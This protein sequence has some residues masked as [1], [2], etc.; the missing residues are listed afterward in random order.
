MELEMT[1]EKNYPKFR[2]N[3]EIQMKFA[4]QVA[5]MSCGYN[6]IVNTFGQPT[7]SSNNNDTFEGTEQCSWLIQFETGDTVSI[8]EE[9]GFGDREHDYRNTT[10]W[11]VNT[12]SVN[13]YEWVKQAIRDSNPNG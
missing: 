12:R 2:T 5:V 13:A 3:K 1:T 8:A 6:H 4:P 10:T 11:K 9:R 7:F